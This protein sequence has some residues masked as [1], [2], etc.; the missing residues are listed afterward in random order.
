MVADR[1][2]YVWSGELW[3]HHI[4]DH[5]VRLV[6]KRKPESGF[7]VDGGKHMVSGFDQ[8]AFIADSKQPAVVHDQNIH[9]GPAC[10][11]A[12]D[13]ADLSFKRFRGQRQLLTAKASYE[14]SGRK[15]RCLYPAAGLPF[16]SKRSRP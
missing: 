4:Q 13:E 2:E 1:T 11:S 3:Q 12:G 14:R 6:L 8:R 7:A 10:T 9:G 15:A 16:Q 5:Q